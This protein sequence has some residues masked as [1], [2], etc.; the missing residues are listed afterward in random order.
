MTAPQASEGC[1]E[2]LS[3]LFRSLESAQRMGTLKLLAPDGER[4]VY[5]YF[6]SGVIEFVK[7]SHHTA[8][9][10]R[11]LVKRRKIT[12]TQLKS[13]L[14]RQ[15][16]APR[17]MRLGQILIEGRLVTHEDIQKA[18]AWQ[19]AEEV[20]A[21]FTWD[22]FTDT[23]YR[24]EPPLDIFDDEDR[25][26]RVALN[27]GSLCEEAERREREL[28]SI[29][30]FIP[31]FHDVCVITTDSRLLGDG[32]GGERELIGFLDG[33]R[34]IEE[35]LEVLPAPDFVGLRILARLLRNGHAARLDGDQL[36]QL[37]QELEDSQ[38]F[39]RARKRYLRALDIGH[40]DFELSR[41]I[42]QIQEAL[43]QTEN[44][45]VRYMDY[46]EQCE[47]HEF[48]DV[49]VETLRHCLTLEPEH[50]E[51][52][53]ALGEL[54]EK[55]EQIDEAI[56]VYEK[57]I[58]LV[59]DDEEA[60]GLWARIGRLKPDSI[61][62]HKKLA[63][64]YLESN[65]RTQAFMELQELA[66]LYLA[67][68]DLESAIPVLRKAH[69]LDPDEIMV[70]ESLAT[71][72]A[73]L[74]RT[75]E[76]ITEFLKLAANLERSDSGGIFRQHLTH[77]YE[78]VVSLAPDHSEARAW[79]AEAYTDKKNSEKA[80]T[81]YKGMLPGL[82]EGE[83]KARLLEVLEKVHSLTPADEDIA[84]ELAELLIAEGRDSEGARILS[85]LA[86][87]ASAEGESDK[88]QDI[89]RSLLAVMP[90]HFE[91]QRSLARSEVSAGK[92]E[93]ATR[94]YLGMALLLDAAD[95]RSDAEEM[96]RKVVELDPDDIAARRYHAELQARSGRPAL[97][98]RQLLQAA[99]RHRDEDNLGFA[100]KMC[101]RVLELDEKNKD[102]RKLLKELD[103]RH[104][105]GART[106]A[107][108]P[109][110]TPP[111]KQAI[112][113]MPTIT[114]GGLAQVQVV[115]GTKN[116]KNSIKKLKAMF[117]RRQVREGPGDSG[118]VVDESVAKKARKGINKLKALR[119]GGFGGGGDDDEGGPTPT[120][121]RNGP[122]G[123][124][125]ALSEGL[126][127]KAKGGINKLKA[128]R[129]GG[130]APAGP[131]V[132]S[133]PEGPG[134]ALS[135]GLSKKAKGG[136][137]KLK[138]L[139]AGGGGPLSSG[140]DAPGEAVSEDLTKKAKGG[141][142]K[143]KAL[144]G[145]GASAG[146]GGPKPAVSAG[147]EAPGQALSA[148]LSKKAKGGISKLKA[149]KLGKAKES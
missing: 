7:T 86:E 61:E 77:L 53:K 60:L 12:E 83:D 106:A 21:C 13:A 110:P 56:E 54:L 44:A 42:G 101:R 80:A 57:A 81:N 49:A 119:G 147:P 6:N 89:F 45:V 16:Q 97:A 128:L 88:E 28:R 146:G 67:E 93:A 135:E 2:K 103:N 30:Q 124:G 143:L 4:T 90:G 82:R 73:R 50:L 70:H 99:K 84:K 111:D 48:Y 109:Q 40:S 85:Q 19:M 22:S 55:T 91:A 79:L 38:E 126:S 5:V 17:P 149:L 18:L 94:R 116:S 139:K 76:A 62:V 107:E 108:I 117:G 33:R 39:R 148:D 104:G 129:G 35:Y 121:I 66:T 37:G 65:D 127:K 145:G 52:L 58:A 34:D 130:A 105:V 95:R 9:L 100:R 15:N 132:S 32:G 14:H 113:A 25:E 120:A 112:K 71:T 3:E 115:G 138:A 96:L 10:G 1:R 59:E 131:A 122:E 69:E 125:Q 87:A 43:E 123:P 144:R 137:N 51:A 63:D 41:R 133:G 72:L 29:R 134:Q 78:K 20:F 24:G 11:A 27:P 98:C 114:G 142:N 141:I 75:D 46:A 64:L 140:P 31:S 8:L 118:N 136:I 36:I 23:F 68:D 74:K 102:A 92:V 26:Y 47:R